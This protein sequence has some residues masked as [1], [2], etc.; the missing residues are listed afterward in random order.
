MSIGC[1]GLM[2]FSQ[3]PEPK[4]PS[5]ETVSLAARVSINRRTA[6]TAM[7]LK[8]LALRCASEHSLSCGLRHSHELRKRVQTTMC[9]R[10][11]L[12]LF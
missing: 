5:S 8:R 3:K 10:R 11:F 7:D 9:L 12:S 2:E 6:K 4:R 1:R